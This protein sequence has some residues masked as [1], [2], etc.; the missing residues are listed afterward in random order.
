MTLVISVIS[1]GTGDHH[2]SLARHWCPSS[3]STGTLVVIGCLYRDTCCGHQVFYS[4]TVVVAISCLCRDTGVH[5]M[6][7]RGHWWPSG[8]LE[9]KLVCPCWEIFIKYLLEWILVCPCWET[10]WPPVSLERHWWPSS[11]SSVST[12]TPVAI[13]CLYSDRWLSGFSSRTLVTIRCLCKTQVFSSAFSISNRHL[14]LK[15]WQFTRNQLPFYKY[16]LIN[17]FI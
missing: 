3:V 5:Q 4:G 2:L 8:L 13:M 15:I 12:G 11:V 6:S 14:K 7:L 1:T 9:C 10:W 16:I 17:V